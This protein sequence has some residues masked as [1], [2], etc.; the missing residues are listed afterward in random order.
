M[1]K[2]LLIQFSEKIKRKKTSFKKV[3][4]SKSEYQQTD[5]RVRQIMRS[6]NSAF[7]WKYFELIL[8][9]DNCSSQ[10]SRDQYKKYV[11]YIIVVSVVS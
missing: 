5:R 3:T 10:K 9:L 1:S 2:I 4:F 6:K 8:M 11:I 7:D